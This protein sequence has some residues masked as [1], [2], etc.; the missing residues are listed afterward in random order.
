MP[1]EPAIGVLITSFR[2]AHGDHPGLYSEGETP[3]IPGQLW[4]RY[5]NSHRSAFSPFK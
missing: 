1:V 5:L 4:V 3:V 2:G